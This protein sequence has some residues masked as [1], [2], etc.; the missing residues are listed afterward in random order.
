MK[1]KLIIATIITLASSFSLVGCGDKNPAEVEPTETETV[2]VTETESSE[3]ESTELTESID[4]SNSTEESSETTNTSEI[5]NKYEG[6]FYIKSIENNGIFLVPYDDKDSIL[7]YG[8]NFFV[9]KE[10]LSILKNGKTSLYDSLYFYD[11]CVLS[12][13]GS[14]NEKY[15]YSEIIPNEGKKIIVDLVSEYKEIKESNNNEN[16]D[17]SSIDIIQ[18]DKFKADVLFNGMWC[19]FY[20]SPEFSRIYTMQEE[21]GD[22]DVT[23][24]ARKGNIK[25]FQI[26]REPV[27]ENGDVSLGYIDTNKKCIY[28]TDKYYY[29]IKTSDE[30]KSNK[31]LID[32]TLEQIEKTI[33]IIE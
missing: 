33:I 26:V 3:S 14:I 12:F 7:D 21:E 13:E 27:E 25:I 19:K 8:D 11:G 2:E 15:S 22:D 30:D 16:R 29:F 4:E 5:D 1:K 18:N 28:K 9:S 17:E 31:E 20:Y 32:S 24:V 23:I 10:N 6:V